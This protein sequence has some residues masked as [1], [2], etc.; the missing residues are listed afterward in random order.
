MHISTDEGLTKLYLT[1][2]EANKI[3]AKVKD[4]IENKEYLAALQEILQDMKK[5]FDGNPEK[6]VDVGTL[7]LGVSSAVAIVVV[8]VITGNYNKLSFYCKYFEFLVQVVSARFGAA[9]ICGMVL[10]KKRW[11]EWTV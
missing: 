9:V 7:A 11:K 4:K 8:G 1:D 10:S 2:E 6:P 3:A 5:E